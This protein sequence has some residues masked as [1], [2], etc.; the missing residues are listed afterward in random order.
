MNY[1]EI[2]LFKATCPVAHIGNVKLRLQAG[3]L[4]IGGTHLG[5]ETINSS[6]LNN[7]H[8][9]TA[10]TGTGHSGTHYAIDAPGLLDQSIQLGPGHLV[11]VAQR[12]MR[13]VHQL[14]KLRQIVLFQSLHSIEYTLVFGNNVTGP[15]QQNL[16]RQLA[17]Q[18]VEP[19]E[20]NITEGF[21]PTFG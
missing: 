15:A 2:R 18:I 4:F 16:L 8:G 19:I 3:P 11:I 20:G 21:K 5:D 12:N 14:P 13:G 17:V 1:M 7:A 6:F 9:T 10:K